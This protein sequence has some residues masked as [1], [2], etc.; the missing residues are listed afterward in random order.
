MKI[1]FET[2]SAAVVALLGTLL[3]G[4]PASAQEPAPRDLESFVKYVQSHHRAPFDREGAVLPKG[5][6]LRLQVNANAPFLLQGTNVKVNQD[7]NP[8][9]K[10]EI[11]AAVDPTN[12]NNYV[13]MS[14]DFRENW[15]HQ[16]YHVSTT[17]GVTWT[18][19]SMVGGADPFTGFVP[20]NF[21]SDPGVAFNTVGNSF[22]STI[23][24][25]LIFDFESDYVNLDTEIETAQGFAGGTYTS[26]LPIVI[27]DQPCNGSSTTFHCP[28]QLDK[29][30]I[31]IDNVPGSPNNGTVYVYYTLFCNDR[32]CRDGDAQVPRF[33]SAIVESH[34]PRAGLPF[35][36]PKLVTG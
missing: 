7:R 15:D 32:V 29:P 4:Q 27:D 28:A 31:T 5:E 30:L 22:L 13:V 12:G 1:N 25:N 35:S 2:F 26:L 24:G 8:W 16:F 19:D 18:D 10:A 34:A 23:T 36:P 9:P 20:L 14:N 3:W 6:V 33:S 17:N 21:Q 11:A